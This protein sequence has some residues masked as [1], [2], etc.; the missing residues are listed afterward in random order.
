MV[1]DWHKVKGVAWLEGTQRGWWGFLSRQLSSAIVCLFGQSSLDLTGNTQ[2]LSAWLKIVSHLERWNADH[3]SSF[4]QTWVVK[5]LQSTF[6]CHSANGHQRYFKA[7]CG[8]D[9]FVS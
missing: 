5:Q 3:W 4:N 6:W 9:L 8:K 1:A 7:K 2:A